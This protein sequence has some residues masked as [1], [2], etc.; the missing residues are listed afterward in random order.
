MDKADKMELL[1]SEMLKI[2]RDKNADYGDSFSKSY[3]EF[4]LTAPVIRMSDKMERLKS[5]SKAEARI[6]DESIRDTLVD[7]ANYAMMTVI[8]MESEDN[9]FDKKGSGKDIAYDNGDKLNI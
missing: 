6:K 5:L 8:E 7:I 2:Y 1:M 3:E 4:G 9:D